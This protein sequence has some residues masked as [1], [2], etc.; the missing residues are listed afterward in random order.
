MW[1]EPQPHLSFL[2]AVWETWVRSLGWEDPLEKGKVTHSNILAWIIP[3]GHKELDTTEQLS[4]FNI[5]KLGSLFELVQFHPHSDCMATYL[6]Y[7]SASC[8][9]Q[10]K[11]S[12]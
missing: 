5:T 7:F 6:L 3:W 4:L 12:L 2:P 9:S 10:I 11:C 1:G 8:P